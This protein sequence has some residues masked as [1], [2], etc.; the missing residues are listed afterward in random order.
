MGML[1]TSGHI[2]IGYHKDESKTAAT[3]PVVGG[4]RYAVP[5]DMAKLMADGTIAVYGRGSMS[6]NSGGEKIFPEEVEKALKS[7]PAVFD[8]IVVGTPSE[9]WGAQVTA[10]V[11]L[12]RGLL[13]PVCA[14]DLRDHCRS[15]LAGYKLPRDAV[16]VDAVRRS[17]SGKPDYRWAKDVAMAALD[18]SVTTG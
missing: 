8:A 12:R 18:G 7:H 14:A 13:D 9:R 3:F 11:Q 10:V 17:P 5:G 15:H 1:A 6:I 4:V 16:F 2:P